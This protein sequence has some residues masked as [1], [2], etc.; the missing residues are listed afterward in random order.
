MPLFTHPVPWLNTVRRNMSCIF[1]SRQ[2]FECSYEKIDKQ[3]RQRMREALERDLR[4]GFHFIPYG[5]TE[6][7]EIQA[8]KRRV[9][10]QDHHIEQ[11]EH[12]VLQVSASNETNARL[13]ARIDELQHVEKH[14]HQFA[15][16][17]ATIKFYHDGFYR[18]LYTLVAFVCVL[19]VSAVVK[20]NVPGL[21][22][23]YV[24]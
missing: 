17:G 1:Y 13:L 18:M 20:A 12:K 5:R 15:V 8:L 2:H 6:Q 7:Q 23:C 3:D 24:G 22:P 9:L 4:D 16:A 19:V 10:Q 11:L 21:V 14:L